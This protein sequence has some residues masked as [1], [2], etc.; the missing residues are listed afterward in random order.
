MT[1]GFCWPLLD[2]NEEDRAN[3]AQHECS[4]HYTHDGDHR[5]RCG[6]S[7]PRVLREDYCILCGGPCRQTE[8]W[9]MANQKLGQQMSRMLEDYE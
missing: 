4:L 7:V 3:Q 9:H 6:E 8:L 2:P 5:C 1:C